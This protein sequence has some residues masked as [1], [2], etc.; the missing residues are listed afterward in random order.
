MATILRVTWPANPASDQVTKYNVFRSVN[1]SAFSL[2]GVVN[3]PAN[4]IDIPNPSGSYR[5]KVQAV[6]VAGVS[7]ES[8]IAD[9]PGVPTK[10]GTPVV[11]TVE[12]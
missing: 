10:P 5:F 12:V 7:P 8:D 4:S 2:Q 1:G 11:E 3:A 6:N 9:G